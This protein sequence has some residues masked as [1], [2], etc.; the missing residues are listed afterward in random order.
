MPELAAHPPLRILIVGAGALG[1]YFGAR[2]LAAGR[3]VTFLVRP[4]TA[5]LL[6][7]WPHI[8]QPQRRPPPAAPPTPHGRTVGRPPYA[9][10]LILLS[11]KAYDLHR[12]STPSPPPSAPKPPS[13][14]CSTAW[15]T[16]T[17]SI[18]RFGPEHVLGGTSIISAT[19]DPRRHHPP[20][21]QLDRLFFGD[22]DHP[23]SPRV[24]SHRRRTLAAQ[25]SIDRSAPPS[26]RTC[27]RSGPSI[28]ASAGIT[29][30]MR[31][32]VGDIV[33]AGAAPLDPPALRRVH[34]RRRRRGLPAHARLPRA[35]SRG[36]LTEPGSAFTASMLRDLESNSPIE[37]HQIIGDLLTRARHRNLPPHS[38][39]SSTPTSA[40]TNSAANAKLPPVPSSLLC[41]A[42][43]EPTLAPPFPD[44]RGL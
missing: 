32:S 38:S 16:W 11:C 9:F 35:P 13:S 30:L 41:L 15:P 22:R 34:R 12:A 19:R 1:G 20:S 23:A 18:S 24:L 7:A 36:N 42:S 43:R 37:S 39:K 27:G 28:A 29:C 44:L 14:P 17:P 40:P 26:S 31:A 25:A 6:A 33:A 4:A 21:Q 8:A 3:N 10:D 2:L 5:A